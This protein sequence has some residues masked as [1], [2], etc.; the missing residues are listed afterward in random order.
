MIPQVA[1]EPV[2]SELRDEEDFR[3]LL[4]DF[5]Q[6]AVERRAQLADWFAAGQFEDIRVTAHQLK[7]S[8]AGY[9]FPELSTLAASLETAC[10]STTRTPADIEQHLDRLVCYLDR[11]RA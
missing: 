1:I 8:G 2:Y 4:E 9:G 7:G 6:A 11:V 5:A 3:P 10:K